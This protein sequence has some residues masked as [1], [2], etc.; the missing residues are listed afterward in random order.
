[1]SL[2][3]LCGTDTREG[4]LCGGRSKTTMADGRFTLDEVLA[5]FPT[6]DACLQ[7][8]TT[9]RYG[10]VPKCPHCGE[11]TRF[12]RRSSVR[13]IVICA[14]CGVHF[15]PCVGTL[16]EKSRLP[17]R[18]WFLAIYFSAVSRN[19][20][21]VSDLQCLF[22]VSHVAAWRMGLLLSPLL[23]ERALLKDGL[24]AEFN[25]ILAAAIAQAAREG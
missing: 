3:M 10:D 1:M 25:R 17:L 4:R 15:S 20:L 12:Y 9:L 11:E 21:N 14:D 24:E 16:F 7:H 5:R 22:G 13:R 2:A 8:L 19:G 23:S 18:I 6:E